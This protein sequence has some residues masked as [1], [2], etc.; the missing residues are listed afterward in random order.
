MANQRAVY[1]FSSFVTQSMSV[2]SGA[3]FIDRQGGSHDLMNSL[4]LLPGGDLAKL[5]VA[6]LH[7]RARGTQES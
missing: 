4:H 2:E 7:G 1:A 3:Q 5:Q 6:S